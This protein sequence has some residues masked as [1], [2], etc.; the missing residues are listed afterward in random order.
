MTKQMQRKN[1]LQ[2]QGR[3]VLMSEIE[4]IG[5][6]QKYFWDKLVP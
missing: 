4:A 6:I 3:V 5:K 1:Y 2:P